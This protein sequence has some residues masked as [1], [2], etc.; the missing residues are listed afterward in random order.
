MIDAYKALLKA[1][2]WHVDDLRLG[3]V[4]RHFD[5]QQA[6]SI[7]GWLQ[8]QLGIR[9]YSIGL[10]VGPAGLG[11]C[12]TVSCNQGLCEEG[13]EPDG[14]RCDEVVRPLDGLDSGSAADLRSARLSATAR[15]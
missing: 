3:E 2:T 6:A 7:N 14:H 1:E 9:G 8:H 15:T 12:D 4:E 13:R 10:P 5:S 11:V